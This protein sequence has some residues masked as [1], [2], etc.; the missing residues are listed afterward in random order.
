MAARAIGIGA[1]V[2]LGAGLLA[3][4][5]LGADNPALQAVVHHVAEPGGRLFLRLL[6]VVVLPLVFASVAVGVA[7]LGDLG[8]VGKLGGVTFGLTLVVSTASVLLGLAAAAVFRPGDA[9]DAAT[10]DALVHR[11]APDAGKVSALATP[12][13]PPLGALVDLLPRNPLAAATAQPPDMLG[14]LLVAALFGAALLALEEERRRPVLDVLEGVL[15]A[16]IAIVGWA[17]A[18]A[19]VCVGLLLFALAASFGFD[20]LAAVGAFVA[21]VVGALAVQFS[22]V[23]TPLLWLAG[24][25]PVRFW[26][27]AREVLLTAFSTS[28][29]N[30]TLPTALRV[31]AERLAIPP[32]IG[33]FVLTVGATANQNGTALF[34]GVAVLFLAQVFGVELSWAQQGQVMVMAVASGIGT[35]GIPSGSLPFVALVLAVVGVPPEALGLLIGVDRLLDMCRTTVNVAGDLVIAALVGRMR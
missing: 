21:V 4:V 2:G 22:V 30:A 26:S 35:A 24:R 12:D 20:L 14:L 6:L 15:A 23:Y 1:A 33:S 9:V 32:G 29:S 13:Q 18:L 34:E 25:N 28:S 3:R 31:A 5:A 16:T 8:R 27:D 7:G 19:P 11:F 17:M 10:R